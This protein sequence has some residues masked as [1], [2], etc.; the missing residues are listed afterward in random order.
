MRKAATQSKRF[1]QA[2]ERFWEKRTWTVPLFI[3]PRGTAEQ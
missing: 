2:L 1:R 3:G